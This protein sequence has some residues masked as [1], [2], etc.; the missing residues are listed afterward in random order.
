[1]AWQAKALCVHCPRCSTCCQGS[2]D[3]GGSTAAAG[4]QMVQAGQTQAGRMEHG[5]KVQLSE[6]WREAEM[7]PAWHP[8]GTGASPW[9]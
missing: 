9:S 6:G 4:P 2:E 1:M 5:E 7:M 3:E 8:L